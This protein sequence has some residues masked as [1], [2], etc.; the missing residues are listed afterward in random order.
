MNK[1]LS[2]K[3]SLILAGLLTF[4]VTAGFI[5][6]ISYV[7][8][9]DAYRL[10]INSLFEGNSDKIE[11]FNRSIR[12]DAD[13][14]N[15]FLESEALDITDT[16]EKEQI[17][18]ER[19]FFNEAVT[20]VSLGD[21]EGEIISV[22]R[23]PKGYLFEVITPG[24]V[25]QTLRDASFREISG[26]T[27]E[28][29]DDSLPFWLCEAYKRDEL[30]WSEPYIS[31]SSPAA[32][33]TVSFPYYRGKE[34]AGA[35][36][37][38]FEITEVYG[39]LQQLHNGLSSSAFIV[40]YDR[41][42]I[43]HISEE[44]QEGYSLFLSENP[45]GFRAWNLYLDGV[46]SWPME[47]NRVLEYLYEDSVYLASFYPF[48]LLGESCVLGITFSERGFT[49]LL[50]TS[51][52]ERIPV[53][54]FVSLLFLFL[55]LL[56]GRWYSKTV[57]ARVASLKKEEV[58]SDVP[59]FFREI[60]FLDREIAGIL[61]ELKEVRERNSALLQEKEGVWK[62]VSEELDA[63]K[64]TLSPQGEIFDK[65]PHSSVL[66]GKRVLLADDLSVSRDMVFYFLEQCHAQ[67]VQATNGKEALELF[68]RFPF[69]LVLLDLKM[70]VMGGL[71]AAV[72]MIQT[73]S[74][75]PVLGITA[76]S[77]CKERVS[78]MEKGMVDV[79]TKPFKREQLYFTIHSV[80]REQEIT[81]PLDF[82]CL[83]A[84]CGGLHE[85]L[86]LVADFIGSLNDLAGCI[87]NALDSYDYDSFLL[88]VHTLK[89]G[90]RS[91]F[92]YSLARSA[93]Y[94]EALAEA[95]R[96]DIIEKERSVLNERVE[97]LLLYGASLLKKHLS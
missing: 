94:L 81:S 2:M 64:H 36:S 72:E 61:S 73:G 60:T 24:A 13:R 44:G 63:V 19:L 87:N 62:R 57:H 56:A 83:A 84:E 75:V 22:K 70:P 82:Q 76:G 85:A 3:W 97:E 49:D 37:V 69:D 20:A 4:A 53:F 65:K 28:R 38:T 51:L 88:H 10:Y 74:R 50:Y 23:V 89:G 5:F 8:A 12:A 27:H 77:S 30:I 15:S 21:P 52:R 68:R 93:V 40:Y 32:A 17:I 86:A 6:Q 41:K 71:E 58:C 66:E 16:L 35:L 26:E 96:Y 46:T 29:R 31:S 14:V 33:I 78:C 79:I 39:L 42:G 55:M 54:L 95:A 92:A 34:R 9:R 45:S 90:A 91:L 43:T 59:H 25:K 80:L 48:P 1:S 67:V 47:E 18:Y 11:Q 7:S